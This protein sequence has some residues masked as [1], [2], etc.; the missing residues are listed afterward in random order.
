MLVCWDNAILLWSYH[1]H[2]YISH[3][4]TCS[5]MRK[6]V[7]KGSKTLFIFLVINFLIVLCIEWQTFLSRSVLFFTRTYGRTIE[8][9]LFTESLSTVSIFCKYSTVLEYF[10]GYYF[11]FCTVKTFPS[12]F[13]WIVWPNVY[14][15]NTIFEELAIEFQI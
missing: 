10:K 14:E 8:G 4:F 13:Q 2:T 7:E 6:S 11:P 12:N 15:L 5:C 3:T 1:F 9:K